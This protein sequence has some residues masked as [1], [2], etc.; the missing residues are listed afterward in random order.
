MKTYNSQKMIKAVRKWQ[1]KN[2]QKVYANRKVQRGVRRGDILKPK[3]CQVCKMY[4][5]R[6][7]G[8]HEDYDKPL[9]VIWCCKA[10]HTG[11][12]RLRRKREEQENLSSQSMAL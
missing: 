5:K 8:H 11:L 2:R 1:R 10:C 6:I 12:D 9:K 4:K 3:H 7:E